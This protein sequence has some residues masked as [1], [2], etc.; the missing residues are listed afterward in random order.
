MEVT[1]V[2]TLPHPTALHIRPGVTSEYVRAPFILTWNCPRARTELSP[3]T[4]T[5]RTFCSREHLVSLLLAFHPASAWS[6][7]SL[8][9]EVQLIPNTGT[10]LASTWC[11]KGIPIP[12]FFSSCGLISLSQQLCRIAALI[13]ISWWANQF[14]RLKMMPWTTQTRPGLQHQVRPAIRPQPLSTAPCPQESPSGVWA[15][16]WFS[17][18]WLIK[19]LL[20]PSQ[21]LPRLSRPPPLLDGY[22]AYVCW[23]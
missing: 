13:P 8:S 9:Q 21:G 23:D 22:G 11:R 2:C 16:A 10:H 5:S 20:S 4:G 18:W 7:P 19:I 17:P 14:K 6:S 12:V 15:F 3:T 1:P